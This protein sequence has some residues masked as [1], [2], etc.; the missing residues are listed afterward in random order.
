MRYKLSL[1]WSLLTV[2]VVGITVSFVA[3]VLHINPKSD[4]T[5]RG[6][7]FGEQTI[8]GVPVHI[9]IPKIK[10]DASIV[11]VGLTSEGA[12]DVPKV[13]MDAAWFDK[14]PRPG[15]AGNSILVGHFG[16]KNST[17]AVFDNLYKIKNGDQILIDDDK[18][19]TMTF[20]V[21]DI[22]WYDPKEEARE[23][24]ISSDGKSH[25]N[26]ITCDGVWDKIA[27]SYSKRIVVF[28]DR[29]I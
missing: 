13:P 12:V 28:A 10:V 21:R 23:V 19:I 11:Q 2:G 22:R 6:I 1:K 18:G 3:A 7:A 24:F 29:K 20:V 17:P 8:P 16:W 26:I 14:S 5:F 27:K 15:E 9:L 4:L 25:L